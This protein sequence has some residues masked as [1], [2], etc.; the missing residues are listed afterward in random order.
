MEPTILAAIEIRLPF[1]EPPRFQT[2]FGAA[3]QSGGLGLKVPL[4]PVLWR[5]ENSEHPVNTLDSTEYNPEV[6]K[7]PVMKPWGDCSAHIMLSLGGAIAS[8][9][10][11]NYFEAPTSSSRDEF[12]QS[13][14]SPQIPGS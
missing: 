7:K 5:V 10:K 14:R 1:G 13:M 4:P 11:R 3:P 9:N 2:K 12:C 8:C 6:P